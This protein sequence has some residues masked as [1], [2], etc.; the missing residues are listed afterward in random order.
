VEILVV[1]D[2]PQMRRLVAGI[3]KGAGHTVHE[4]T[5]GEEGIK[6]FVRVHPVLVITDLVMPG[7]EGIEM[8]QQLRRDF[9]AIPILA[10]SGGS[11]HAVYLR[12]ANALGATAVLE[13]PFS[14]DEF[15][16]VVAELLGRKLAGCRSE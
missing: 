9:P 11:H 8:I 3:L 1:D 2:D 7:M 14:P 12:A 4:A 16:S 6:L 10:I 5:N 13:K 15:L